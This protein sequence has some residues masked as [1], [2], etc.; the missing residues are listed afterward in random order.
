MIAQPRP[1][2]AATPFVLPALA[3]DLPQSWKSTAV[4]AVAG[5]R[6]KLLRMDTRLH[7]HEVHDHDEALLVV[8]GRLLLEVEGKAVTVDA[9]E[10]YVVPAG[11]VH[12][13][14]AGSHGTLLVIDPQPLRLEEISYA[15]RLL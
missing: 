9:G 4:A 1:E 2:T 3:A 10:L 15:A 8:D 6:L 12:G 13:V 11:T 14:A 5:A 7:P